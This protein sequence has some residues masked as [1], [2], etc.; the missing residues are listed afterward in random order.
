MNW[1]HELRA[2]VNEVSADEVPDLI[3]E[4]ARAGAVA[5]QRLQRPPAPS[6]NGTSGA[7][8]NRYI[9]ADEVAEWLG[10]SPKFVYAHAKDLGADRLSNR[11]V[12]FS[13]AAVRRFITAR[14]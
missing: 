2:I 6:V 10:V 11:C 13:H 5:T 9:S 1:R 8:P 3:G 14:H 7:R 4:L 12:R